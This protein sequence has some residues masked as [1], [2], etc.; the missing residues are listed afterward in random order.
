[1]SPFRGFMEDLLEQ[2]AGASALPVDWVDGPDFVDPSIDPAPQRGPCINTEAGW[3]P[4][5]RGGGPE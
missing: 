5:G 3:V 4:L 1:M 2:I